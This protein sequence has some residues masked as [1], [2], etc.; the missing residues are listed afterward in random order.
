MFHQPIR[1]HN[2]LGLVLLALSP[3]FVTG[4]DEARTGCPFRYD[5]GGISYERGRQF[6][7]V[8]DRSQ[9]LRLADGTL[10][11]EALATFEEAKNSRVLI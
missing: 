1:P 2:G 11:P 4:F 6:G 7:L 10:N 8:L 3:A 9:P 5:F